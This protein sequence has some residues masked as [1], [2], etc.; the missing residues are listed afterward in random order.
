[1]VNK[2]DFVIEYVIYEGFRE[3]GN[4]GKKLTISPKLE[5]NLTGTDFKI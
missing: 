3:L 1:M 5:A 4:E 2:S